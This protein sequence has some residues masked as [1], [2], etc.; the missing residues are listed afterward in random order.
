LSSFTSFVF[1]PSE[2]GLIFL[3]EKDNPLSGLIDFALKS[4][5]IDSSKDFFNKWPDLE[6]NSAVFSYLSTLVRDKKFLELF[7]SIARF[8]DSYPKNRLKLLLE[9]ENFHFSFLSFYLL[10]ILAVLSVGYGFYKGAFDATKFLFFLKKKIFD[11]NENELLQ[12]FLKQSNFK[13][14]LPLQID[15]LVQ[16]PKPSF[17]SSWKQTLSFSF[18]NQHSFGYRIKIKEIKDEKLD[19]FFN[20]F[21]KIRKIAFPSL[22]VLPCVFYFMFVNDSYPLIQAVSFLIFL[23]LCAVFSI[24]GFE[25][26]MKQQK[27]DFELVM[28][29]VFVLAL[30]WPSKAVFIKYCFCLSLIALGLV[31]LQFD[32]KE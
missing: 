1:I 5:Q 8:F 24:L 29:G 28:T 9:D 11:Q 7:S 2:D 27:I 6:K 14:A 20:F 4:H 22:F 15:K 26:L 12:D 21:S 10:F 18:K 30:L 17:L 19:S 13:P 32:V 31:Q 23:S 25:G 16:K 3:D